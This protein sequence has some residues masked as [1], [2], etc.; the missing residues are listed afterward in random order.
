M[1]PQN[2]AAVITG[3]LDIRADLDVSTH[4]SSLDPEA[5]TVSGHRVIWAAMQ[6]IAMTGG[7][8]DSWSLAKAMQK[9]GASDADTQL[10]D[11]YFGESRN[12]WG[13]LDLRPRIEQV[14]EAFKRRTVARAMEGLSGAMEGLSWP[15]V[16]ERLAEVSSKVSQA[17]NPRFQAGTDYA[18]QFDAY[19]SGSP[20]LPPES[21]DNRVTFG[22]EGID[23]V[24]V[25]NP[26]RLIVIGGLP[27]A[28]KTALALQAAIRTTQEG[29]RVGMASLEM[30]ADE[31]GARIV[32]NV[33]GVNSIKALKYGGKADPEDAW[34]L[35]RVRKN[36]VGLH[37][38][39]GDPWP[40][41][42]AALVREHRK[43]PLS[44]AIVDYLQLM[45]MTETKGRRNDTEAQQIAQITMGA[46]RLAQRLGINVILLSQ[47]NREVKETE[48]PTLQNFLGSGQIERD[49]DI[50]L[51]LW[52]TQRS[53]MKGQNRQ[54]KC[55]IA[56]NRG[57]ERYGL[58]DMEFN[59][60]LNRFIGLKAKESGTTP[61]Q[62]G[63]FETTRLQAACDWEP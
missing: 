15:E 45:G 50:A 26:G 57:G 37:G 21:R 34:N 62:P 32:A 49:I 5:F 16:E 42:E 43:T 20:I 56:K 4:L 1:T 9:L 18:A 14:A 33:C 53:Y 63:Q 8:I 3:I 17:G 52:N 25:A 10:A 35:G 59:A 13:S 39:A 22:V 44:V 51:L 11:R 27:S 54:I 23:E 48:E 24:I 29:R 6:S 40:A 31:I 19:L 30:D 36:I 41:I 60:A 58:V 7:L 38:C 55:R 46:K 12:G 2:E 28:G 61:F 47:F